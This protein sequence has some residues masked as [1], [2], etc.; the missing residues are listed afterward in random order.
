MIAGRSVTPQNTSYSLW[1]FCESFPSNFLS[2]KTKVI[3][4]F[5]S[6]ADT[7]EHS[8]WGAQRH[9]DN[10]NEGNWTQLEPKWISRQ[11]E[12]EKKVHV[13]RYYIF[14]SSKMLCKAFIAVRGNSRWISHCDNVQPSFFPPACCLYKYLEPQSRGRVGQEPGSS[15]SN[16]RDFF[17]CFFSLWHVVN[18]SCRSC[19]LN[20]SASS[21]I[22]SVHNIVYCVS[23]LYNFHQCVYSHRGATSQS[24]P[25]S[26]FTFL[27]LFSLLL[28]INIVLYS[29]I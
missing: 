24:L 22:S 4:C 16:R 17:V 3:N 12:E 13:V 20:G 7:A 2:F 21:L 23:L 5:K 29:S 8:R 6:A 18:G 26:D 14:I 10:Q 27:L 28:K 11:G 19:R 9:G 15:Y 1:F 25:T